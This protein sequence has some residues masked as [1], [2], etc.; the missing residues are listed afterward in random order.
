VPVDATDVA[1]GPRHLRTMFNSFHHFPPERARAILADAVRKQCAIAVFEGI[2]HR[3]FGLAAMPLQLPAM[4]LLTPLVRPFRWS[5]LLLTYALPLIPLLVLFD[6]TVSMFRLYLEDE[7]RE[8]VAG[9]P[10]QE[11]YTW[12]IGSTVIPGTPVGILHLVGIPVRSHRE[13]AESRT[14]GS[15]HG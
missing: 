7:L 3:A 2:N 14:G 5:R 6:G 15:S 13:G 8:L 10:G 12:D 11:T 9:V 1:S 4:L